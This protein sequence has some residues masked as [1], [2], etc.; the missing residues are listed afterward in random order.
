MLRELPDDLD[1]LAH[2]T[3]ALLR[4]REVPSGEALLRIA[5]AYAVLDLS[6]RGV[7]SWMPSQGL[8]AVSDVAVLGRLR[9]SGA[10]LEAVLLTLLQPLSPSSPGSG[11]PLRVVLADATSLSGPASQGTDY[12]VH[13]GYDPATARI[14]QLQLTDEHQGESLQHFGM[15]PG[16]LWIADRGYGRVSSLQAAHDQGAHLLVRFTPS[17]LTLYD[18][19]GQ[20]LSV[21]DWAEPALLGALPGTVAQRAAFVHAPGQ[22]PLP[23]RL[24]AVLKTQQATEQE[25]KRIRRRASRKGQQVKPETLRAAAYV[26]LVSTVP[27]AQASASV[28]AELYRVRWQVELLFKRLK[29]LLL[30]D[31]L[32][33]HDPGLARSYLLAKLIA[34]V[35]IERWSCRARAFPP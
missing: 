28:L 19:E 15:R 7:A 24:L 31:A 26:L 10:F 8:P 3:G 13:V 35:L 22:A 23:V 34:A 21:L 12:R 11:L 1:A 14:D 30:L 33:A 25:Q 18:G 17:H 29:S 9:Q 6:L 32:R 27:E 2:D 5:L 16:E 4:K 20:P